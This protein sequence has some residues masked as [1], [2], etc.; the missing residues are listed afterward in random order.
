MKWKGKKLTADTT[1]IIEHRHFGLLYLDVTPMHGIY[2]RPRESQAAEREYL[3]REGRAR[4]DVVTLPAGTALADAA[5][6]LWLAIPAVYRDLWCSIVL[7]ERHG[8][9]WEGERRGRI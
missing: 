6:L 7:D 8:L 3:R 2:I 1:Y 4:L 5:L 9:E